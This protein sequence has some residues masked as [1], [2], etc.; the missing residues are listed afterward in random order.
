VQI[1][2]SR[3]PNWKK[4][5]SS[6]T[7]TRKTATLSGWLSAISKMLTIPVSGRRR[8]PALVIA[9]VGGTVLILMMYAPLKQ[10]EGGDSAIYDYIAQSILRGRIPYRDVVDIKWPGGPY[11]SAMAMAVGKAVGVRDV[12][13]VR[14]FQI[15]ACG[16][17]TLVTFMVGVRLF[18]NRAAATIACLFPLMNYRFAGWVVGGTQPKLMMILFGMLSLLSVDANEPFWG[19]FC[20]MLS[21]LCWQPGLLFTGVIFLS[22]SKYLTNW[23]DL[24]ALKVAVGAAVPLAVLFS[25]FFLKGAFG[26]F[27]SWTL[28]YNYSVFGPEAVRTLPEALSRIWKIVSKIFEGDVP[29]VIFSAVGFL[30][31]C[32]ERVYIRFTGTVLGAR[33]NGFEDAIVIAPLVYL[34]FC[35]INFQAGPDLIPL[36]PFIG[37]FAAWLLVRLGRLVSMRVSPSK[38]VSVAR[39][40]VGIQRVV[41]VCIVVSVVVRGAL[42]S[43]DGPMLPDQDRAMMP[44]AELLG[45]G[46]ELYVHGAAEYLVLLN[47]PN[48]NPYVLLDWDAD[49]FAA[50]RKP[51]GFQQI[52]DEMEAQRPKVVVLSRLN[53]LAH[54]RELSSWAEAHYDELKSEGRVK[55]Y[56]RKN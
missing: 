55:L 31:L 11:L 44:I 19:G 10:A 51:G 29:I 25:Y 15:I 14:L 38:T 18:G 40:E 30:W 49:V 13:A 21:C 47:K 20:S 36:F 32:V 16:L 9:A 22:E 27:W 37:L 5:S 33:R 56:V 8:R 52:V 39:W 24:R 45:P 23:R 4:H 50:A 17:L 54:G 3:C 6:K 28:T 12:I 7:K 2:T 46:D 26:D 43:L 34:A 1:N 48:L 53:K 41:A 42:Y 35:V